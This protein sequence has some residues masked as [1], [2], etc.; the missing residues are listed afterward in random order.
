MSAALACV[1]QQCLSSTWPPALSSSLC[2]ARA[3]PRGRQACMRLASS[4][5]PRAQRLLCQARVS[6]VI[7]SRLF[8]A[9]RHFGRG[10][11]R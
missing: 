4:G 9:L 6:L 7:R 10:H 8:R 3:V 2:I 5:L 11:L 1:L